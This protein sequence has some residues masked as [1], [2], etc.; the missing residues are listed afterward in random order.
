MRLPN[1]PLRSFIEAVAVAVWAGGHT[2]CDDG[3][4]PL[5]NLVIRRLGGNFFRPLQ[6]VLHFL[7][8]HFNWDSPGFPSQRGEI[9]LANLQSYKLSE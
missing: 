5:A 1:N 3:I 6:P 4:T 9:S 7:I 2:A 8:S